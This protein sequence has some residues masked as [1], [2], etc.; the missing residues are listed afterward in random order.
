MRK[1]PEFV[2]RYFTRRYS[3]AILRESEHILLLLV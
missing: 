3:F 2:P 1:H